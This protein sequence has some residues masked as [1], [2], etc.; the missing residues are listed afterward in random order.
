MAGGSWRT[1][2]QYT[3]ENATGTGNPERE[4]NYEL[5]AKAEQNYQAT[6]KWYEAKQNIFLKR[7]ISQDQQDQ[8]II[9][10]KFLEA[11]NIIIQEQWQTVSSTIQSAATKNSDGT[12]SFS[13]QKMARLPLYIREKYL[14]NSGNIKNLPSELGFTYEDF[15]ATQLRK[16]GNK[17]LDANQNALIAELFKGIEKTGGLYSKSAMRQEAEIRADIMI[18]AGNKR[19][20]VLYGK[21]KDKYLSVELQNKFDIQEA[22]TNGD[23]LNNTLLKQY[24]DSNMF[25]FSMKRWEVDL[26]N[27]SKH[28]TSIAGLR[29]D[30]NSY[31]RNGKTWNPVYAW[32][33]MINRVSRFLLNIL[34]P[35]NIGFILGTQFMWSSEFLSQALL[36]M[37]LYTSSIAYHAKDKYLEIFPYISSGSVYATRFRQGRETAF[38]SITVKR[39]Y[40]MQGGSQGN[41]DYWHAWQV[42]FTSSEKDINTDR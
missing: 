28:L 1:N 15:M 40:E 9:A 10:D 11:I 17:V 13:E 3:Y 37:N 19:D 23:I 30:I 36:F 12:Y 4:G 20:G 2:F 38:Q 29:D 39:A 16:T 18:G 25:G 34:G 27:G 32:K 31:Y 21:G 22:Q 14:K 8:Q 35:N 42:Q 5:L 33:F 6:I 24:L 41:G 26:F 7:A